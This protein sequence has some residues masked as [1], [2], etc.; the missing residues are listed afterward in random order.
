MI[1]TM[2]RLALLVLVV[3]ACGGGSTPA[4]NGDG[5]G[6]DGDGALTA[7]GDSLADRRL[8]DD[9][10]AEQDEAGAACALTAC[11]GDLI[12]NWHLQST[13]YGPGKSL[14][15]LRCPRLSIDE[16][17]LET[18]GDIML[19][20]NMTYTLTLTTNGIGVLSYDTSCPQYTCASLEASLGAGVTCQEAANVCTC[21]VPY[22]D[23]I[24][25]ESGTVSLEQNTVVIKPQM[26]P[27][28][29]EHR[30]TYCVSGG[31]MKMSVSLD[32]TPG[33][34]QVADGVYRLSRR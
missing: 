30:H 1:S 2:E 33:G 15:S 28:L 16:R 18:T 23:E 8:V 34:E 19:N 13:C 29:S 32:V 3:G 6:G 26:P 7:A 5:D 14:S 12:G 21:N 10:A 4:R 31:E 27:G 20:A 22:K 25:Q 9:G 11:G 24:E 17:G